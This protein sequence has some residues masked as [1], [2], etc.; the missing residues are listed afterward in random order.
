MTKCVSFCLYGNDNVYL[1]KFVDN[2]PIYKKFFPDY[3]IYLFATENYKLNLQLLNFENLIIEYK[4]YQ[5]SSIGMM[6]RYIPILENKA[7]VCFIRDVDYLPSEVEINL[8][9]QFLQSNSTFHIIRAH[10]DHV[11]PIM[12]GLFGIKSPL[13]PLFCDS[14]FKWKKKNIFPIYNT[15][16]LFLSNYI[17]SKVIKNSLIHTSNVAFAY[18]KYKQFK[19]ENHLLIGVDSDR[20]S[21]DPSKI[22][23]FKIYPPVWICNLFNYKFI[24][25]FFIKYKI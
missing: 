8:I 2:L 19:I 23:Y 6:W 14:Y 11:M 7:D 10:Y 20:H 16:Q 5:D 25:N 18:E 4:S 22:I 24:C 17:Y 21:V 15:D 13:Y 12:G 1:D 9:N 3:K